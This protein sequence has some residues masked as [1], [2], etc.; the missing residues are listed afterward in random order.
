MADTK[1]A[2]SAGAGEAGESAEVKPQR[3]RITRRKA[4][5]E[6]ARGYFDALARRDVAAV[7]E[8]WREDGVLD[9]V[10]LGVLRGRDEIVGF[11]RELFAAVPDLETT[12]SRLVAGERQVA[13]EWRSTGHFTGASFQGIEPTGNHLELRGLELI[14]VD[15]GENVAGTAYY[16][17]M[18]FARQVGMMPPLDSGAERAIKNAFNTITKV[19]RAVAERRGGA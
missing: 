7:A 4:V 15:E 11:F 17:G 12:V 14:E 6:H 10:P 8:H 9:L 3:R 19:R 18:A 1:T 13:V 5:E 16:D 2:G